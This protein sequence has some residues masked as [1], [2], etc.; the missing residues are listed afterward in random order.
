MQP[1]PVAAKQARPAPK[2]WHLTGKTRRQGEEGDTS[3]RHS[4]RRESSWRWTEETD[5]TGKRAGDR[6]SG[7]GI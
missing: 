6:R 3:R 2:L 4:N 1:G 7:C 5:K